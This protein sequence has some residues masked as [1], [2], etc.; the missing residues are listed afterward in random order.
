MPGAK[1]KYQLLFDT[2]SLQDGFFTAMQAKAAGYDTN[3]QTYHVKAG[4]W[5]REGRGIYRLTNYPLTDRPDLSLWFLWSRDRKD[6]PLGVFSHETALS[7]Y[8][9]SDVNPARIHMTVPPGFRRRC[10]IPRILVLHVGSLS[11]TEL[12]Q[13]GWVSVTSPIRTLVDVVTQGTLSRDLLEQAVKEAS[14][15]GMV[16]QFELKAARAACPEFDAFLRGGQS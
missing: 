3:S 5:R 12:S 16:T 9:L 13:V 8:E 1:E 11:P 4:N 10:P 6:K 15:K 14:D 7:L 2:A